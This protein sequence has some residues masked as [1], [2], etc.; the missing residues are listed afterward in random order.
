MYIRVLE[1]A[2][3]NGVKITHVLTTH[4]HWDHADGNQGMV[5]AIPGLVVVGGDDRIQAITKKMSSEEELHVGTL[6]IKILFTPC[7]TSGH[8]LYYVVDS[9][10][11]KDSPAVLFTGDTLFVA[12]C[13]R[14]FE[15]TGEQMHHALNEVIASLPHN[16]LVYVGHEY[17]IANLKFARHV[18]PDN[19]HVADKIAEAE[20]T[21]ANG[22][23][24]V[25]SSIAAELSF[26]PFM[27]VNEPAVRKSLGLDAAASAAEVMAALREAKNTYK[28]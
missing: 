10:Q 6:T 20:K 21:R 15:G 4:H 14:F 7:H 11:P 16:T 28:G 9:S 19:K 25:P 23:F 24:T 26:N 8:V 2:K 22:L 5:D 3:A 12:G 1:A 18:E 27:R 13:G 17:T